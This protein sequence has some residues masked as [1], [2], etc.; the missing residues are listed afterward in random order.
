[1]KHTTRSCGSWRFHAI[2]QSK[3]LRDYV[4]ITK[5]IAVKARKSC[6][7][8]ETQ[9]DLTLIR[10]MQHH[11]LAITAI[12]DQDIQNAGSPLLIFLNALPYEFP[13]KC[14]RPWDEIYKVSEAVLNSENTGLAGMG[15]VQE[16]QAGTRWHGALLFTFLSKWPEERGVA[17]SNLYAYLNVP[18]SLNLRR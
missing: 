5:D 15:E 16:P 1:M 7:D 10:S 14:I 2:S 17:A 9:T 6:Q 8:D 3:C 12:S 18:K 4:Q 11:N 13:A